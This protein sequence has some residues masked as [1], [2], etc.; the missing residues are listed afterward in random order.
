MQEIIVA[1]AATFGLTEATP[2]Q[3][4]IARHHYRNGRL[5][6]R[7]YI[8]QPV[9]LFIDTSVNDTGFLVHIH[10]SDWLGTWGYESGL[11]IGRIG[12]KPV[13]FGCNLAKPWDGVQFEIRR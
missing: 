11:W 4:D 8:E 5:V 1:L 10:P 3:Q 9:K 2:A 12:C 7:V 13:A 6:Y